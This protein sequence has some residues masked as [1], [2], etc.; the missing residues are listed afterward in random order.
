[1]T[2]L[3]AMALAVAM[4]LAAPAARAADTAA[5][6]SEAEILDD[7]TIITTQNMDFG[8]MAQPSAPGTVVMTPSVTPT[9]TTT[10]GIIRVGSCQ[11]AEFSGF[12]TTNQI[13]R[14]QLPNFPVIISNGVETMT[15]DA[16][17]IS[18]D[19]SLAYVSGNPAANGLVRYRIVSGDGRFSFRVGGTL[20]VNANQGFGQYVGTFDVTVA[21]Q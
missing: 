20:Y 2:R 1:M 6:T 19:P 5:A 13:V 4:S 3:T 18:G 11:P 12:G 21:Y 15:I 8:V 14:I 7:I 17:S 16:R 10:G 9:C